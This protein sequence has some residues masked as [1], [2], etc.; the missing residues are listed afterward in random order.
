MNIE[1]GTI[2]DGT[3][4]VNGQIGAGGGGIV[5]RA[6]H[7][8][9]QTDVVIKKIKEEVREKVELRQEVD[10]LKELK[11]P[12]LPRVYDFLDTEDGVYTIMDF[13]E[14]EDLDTALK[15]HGKFDAETVKKWAKQLGDVLSY[16]HSRQ[17]AII[18]SD[19]K[20]ANIM[21]TKN[22]DI[23][24]IDF[25]I[26]LA[27][28]ARA[29]SAVGISAGF[30]P[31]EQ[32]RDPALYAKITH[33]YTLQKLSQSLP[34][35]P[36]EE[37][38]ELL[39]SLPE[40]DRTVLFQD[41]SEE[42][43]TVLLQQSSTVPPRS[44]A[45]GQKAKTVADTKTSLPAY[46]TYMGKG[47]DT[48]SDIYSLG[49]TLYAL[50]T[51]MEPP[52]DFEQRVPLLETGIQI[53]EGFAIVLEKMMQLHPQDRYQN[54]MEFY[55][56]IVNCHKLERHYIQM[57]RRRMAIRLACLLGLFVFVL[58]CF[59]IVFIRQKEAN[60]RYV[61]TI[62]LAQENMQTEELESAA[63]WIEQ[64]KEMNAARVS[65]YKE[66]IYLLYLQGSWEEC[67]L[68]GNEYI[69]SMPFQLQTDADREE[70]GDIYYITGNACYELGEYGNAVNYLTAALDYNMH[71]GM[72]F[73]DCAIAYAKLG[74]LEQAMDCLEK[75]MELGISED[76]V[77][78]VEGELAHMQGQNEKAAEQLEKA[79]ALTEDGILQ[80]R[81]ILLAVEVYQAMGMD[82]IDREIQLLERYQEGFWTNASYVLIEYLADAYARKAQSNEETAE[83]YYQ[84]ALSL[85]SQ[86]LQQGY[87]TY[88]L[89]ENIAILYENMGD[90]EAAEETLLSM[91]EEYPLRYEVYK[92]L[93]YLEADK[94]Q[95]KDN[96]DRAYDAM[97][98]YYEKACELYQD[99]EQDMEMQMLENMMQELQDGGWF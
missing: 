16:L 26:S 34:S 3:Y 5:Y 44:T 73:R 25:N 81:A 99:N 51:G 1:K 45:L 8:R 67:V 32:Y 82:G 7:L 88:Q 70:F 15:H 85:F 14:G 79:I 57:K 36:V 90:L 17:P 59:G 94:Q 69:N 48:R 42:D 58:L 9:L 83:E 2:L 86:I 76:S 49:V 13:I 54:G 96:V 72:Y 66:E 60:A 11:H 33:N 55:D 50:L 63:A 78:M 64:A 91:L 29:E 31:P 87:R 30:S 53:S 35:L 39:H 20:P 18:H 22:G 84:K 21:L 95:Q 40:E 75:G 52:A 56:A 46:T 38:T 92:R 12:Y 6:K 68:Q 93:A 97:H 61:E 71:N 23:C 28:G 77:C 37:K 24:L 19:I 65:A 10:I 62:S 89:Q 43:R 74:Q 4:E 47:I 41:L 98:T 27:A 80:K